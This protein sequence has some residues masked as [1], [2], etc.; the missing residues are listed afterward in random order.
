MLS[1][2]TTFLH[3]RMGT[4]SSARERGLATSAI[5]ASLGPLAAGNWFCSHRL[6]LMKTP[7]RSKLNSVAL[8]RGRTTGRTTAACRR[9]LPTF[10]ERGC[11][12]VCATDPHGRNLGFLDRSSFF[13]LEAAPQMYSRG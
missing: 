5:Y 12:V 6:T 2:F 4:S 13:F 10:A 11:R 3:L 9:S 8:V 7:Y 1:F